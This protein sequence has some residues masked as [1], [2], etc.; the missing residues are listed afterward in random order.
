MQNITCN[1]QK[2]TIDEFK[3][4]L[5]AVVVKDVDDKVVTK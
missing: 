4:K 5:L 3:C 2:R 1:I